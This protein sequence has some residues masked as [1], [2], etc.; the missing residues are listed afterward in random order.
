[1]YVAHLGAVRV[2]PRGGFWTASRDAGAAKLAEAVAAERSE[3]VVVLGD[4]NGTTDDRALAGLTSRLD[5]AQTEAGDGLGLSWPASF[6]MARIDQILL[7]G[8][9]ARSSWVL[10]ETGSDHLPVGAWISW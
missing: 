4:M 7:K 10:P 5:S 9:A 2:M 3:R 8:V 6:P 1:V